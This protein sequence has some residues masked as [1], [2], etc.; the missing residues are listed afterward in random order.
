MPKNHGVEGGVAKITYRLLN[1][2]ELPTN[3]DQ[4]P[5]SD[6]RL[7]K[8]DDRLPKSNDRKAGTYQQAIRAAERSLRPRDK[9]ERRGPTQAKQ[10][11]RFQGLEINLENYCWFTL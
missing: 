4:S 5:K 2:P 10:A 8:S 1:I 6:D 3:D 11:E 7:P 9:R